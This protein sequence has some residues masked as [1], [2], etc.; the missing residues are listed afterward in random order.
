LSWFEGSQQMCAHIRQQFGESAKLVTDIRDTVHRQITEVAQGVAKAGEST[1]QV[2]NVAEPAAE[3]R[4]S[5]TTRS[6]AATWA[7]RGSS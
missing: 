6:S 7:R 2:L 3:P 1:K 4:W 5:S